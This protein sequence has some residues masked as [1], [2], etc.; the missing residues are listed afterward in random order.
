MGLGG[1]SEASI[2][3]TQTLTRE[4]IVLPGGIIDPPDDDPG[5]GDGYGSTFVFDEPDPP[6]RNLDPPRIYD[7]E[8][9]IGYD[10]SIGDVDNGFAE[11]FLP[12]GIGDGL[13][14]IEVTDP[15]SSLFGDEFV[16]QVDPTTT[17]GEYDEIIDFVDLLDIDDTTFVRSFRL[18]GIELD[19]MIDP[20]SPLGF[21]TGLTF[22]NDNGFQL[23][24]TSIMG[25]ADANIIPQPA[26]AALGL[27]ALIGLAGRR[28]RRLRA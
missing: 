2:S 15:E 16:V 18:L 4:E 10:Y 24:Q 3:L 6:K 7:P 11:V 17:P 13:F 19:E 23:L 9:A 20:D 28:E 1:L 12:L 27:A 26:A 25:S 8:Y 22:V 14:T 21:P 5:V